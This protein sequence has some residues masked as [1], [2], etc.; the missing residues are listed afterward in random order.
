MISMDCN[1]P[2]IEDFI[3]AKKNTDKLEGCNISVRTDGDFIK[4]SPLMHKLA[5]NNWN[6]AEPGIL[7]WDNI[8]KNNLL[9]EY[10]KN[11]EFEYAGV[12]PCFTGNMKLLTTQ[13]YKTFEELC[14]TYPTIINKNG[15]I[16]VSHVWCSGEKD[17]IKL[18]MS[19]GKEIT[20]TPNHVFLTQYGDEVEAQY[21][22][23]R[24]VKLNDK[25]IRKFDNEYIGYGFIQGDGQLT[26]LNKTRY[27]VVNVGNKDHEIL[28]LFKEY[29]WEK[30]DRAIKV[31][32][33]N[34]KLKNLGFDNKI[35]NERDIPKGFE[36]MTLDQK[37]SFLQGMYTANGR[38]NKNHRVS[39]KTTSPA[40]ALHLRDI[41]EEY[42]DIDSNITVNNAKLV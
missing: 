9:S 24:K 12:N 35:A 8:N 15:D 13:G 16:S 19:N 29:E 30:N 5:V 22:K 42:F 7:Y 38:K 34:D 20:C 6:Y 14:E 11:G 28:N 41:L 39:Y 1:H 3:D 26:S 17:T 40:L 4:N 10:I 21:L 32:N 36:S 25:P 2:D 37:A 33:I 31:F 23:G 27:M 18:K